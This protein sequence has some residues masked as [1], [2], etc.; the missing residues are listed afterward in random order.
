MRSDQKTQLNLN[1]RAWPR[2]ARVAILCVL[3][4]VLM[5]VPS[6]C[7]Q[8]PQPSAQRFSIVGVV[9]SGNIPIP[10]ATVTATNSVTGDK[11]V[12]WTDVDG[13]YSLLVSTT[14]RYTLH[15]EMAAFAPTTR[16]IEVTDSSVRADLAMSLLSR[17]QQTARPAQRPTMAGGNRGFQSLAVLQGEATGESSAGNAGDQV[18]PPGMP[19]PGV[20]PDAATESIAFSGNSSGTGMFGMSSDEMQ[21]RM[22]EAREQQGGMGGG[23]GGGFGGGPGGGGGGFGGGGPMIFGGG[24]GRFDINRPHGMVYYTAADSALNAA[25]Y[26]LT[27]QPSIKPGYLNNRFGVSLGGPLNIP[28]IYKGGS[29]TFFFLNYNGSRGETPYDSFSTVPVANQRAGNF[30]ALCRNGFAN[31][32]CNDRDTKGNVVNQLYDRIAGQ[33]I[34]NNNLLDSLDPNLKI[35]P[36]AQGLLKY[37]PPPNLPGSVQNFHFVT[38]ATSNFDD[39]NIRLMHAFGSSSI[40]PRRRGPQNNLTLGLHYHGANTVL[41]NPFP[42]VGG[43]TTGRSFDVPVGYTRSIGKLI[44]TVRVDYNRSR[45]STRNLY[46]F[47]QNIAGSLGIGGI[48]QNPFDWGLPNLSFSHFGSLTDTNPQLLRNQTLTFSDNMIWNHGK[49][50]WRWGG[51]FRRIQLNTEAST[52]ARG[53]FVFTGANTAQ[54]VGGQPMPNTGFDFA[55][56]LLG[57]PQQTRLQTAAQPGD[58]NYHFRG[59]S[60]DLYVQDEW[61]LR[62]NL[63]FNLGLRY[64]YVSP[65]TE[66]NDRIANLIL[67]PGFPSGTPAVTLVQ[68]GQGYPASLVRPDRNNFA[69]RVG[70]A[71]KATPQMV[72]RAGYGINY[73]TTA[74]QAIAQQL[75]FQPPFSLTQTNVQAVAGDLTLKS[76][77]PTPAKGV[78]TNNF[79]VDPN[80]RLGYVQIWNLDVQQTIKPTLLLNLD[81]TGTKGTRLDIVDDPNRTPTGILIPSV[82]PF[83]WEIAQGASVAHA[84]TARL[85]KRLQH[86]I[87]I[88]GS[89]TFSKSIDNASTIGGGATVVAQNALKLAEE[90]GLSSFDQRHKFTADYLWELPFGHDRR[91]LTGNGALR[92]MFGDWNWSGDWTIASG[93]P[94]TP[95]VLGNISDVNRGTNGTLRANVVPGQPVSISDQSID[96]W[97]NTAAFVIPAAG[98]FGDARRNS[99]EGAGSRVF[100]MAFTKIIPL[101]ESRTLEVRAQLA[102]VFN[103]P[104]YAA[105]DT[106]VNSPSFGRVVSVGSMRTIQVTARFRF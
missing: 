36:I 88:G 56:F 14:G 67:S 93:L 48:S 86:G 41:T 53:T 96:Q 3:T 7:A 50:T 15:T 46:A 70:I 55:D 95:R 37:I 52:D 12:T 100:N 34:P 51:D 31:G 29:K 43:N 24:R 22:R 16:E 44:N 57:F 21:Q 64:E 17:V 104:Q 89:Y 26:S 68:P 77:F 1:F 90:R 66:L 82:Q 8:D 87:S 62:G 61:K 99:I 47:T 72:L 33:P 30:S 75:A 101:K 59:N 91:W 85:R 74:Y 2:Q 105:I 103:M 6:S 39:F 58:N 94:F 45:A 18:V 98:E 35:S 25:P 92:A 78:V 4:L 13:T 49:H 102:N 79:A 65:F 69:P 38:A 19:V 40:G 20:A 28:K 71:W 9:K 83:N 27:G 60:W 73:N 10:G 97:F 54:I 23:G 106:T 5:P 81:Y 11:V 63:S 76:G 80:Y 42:S 32:V 84:G